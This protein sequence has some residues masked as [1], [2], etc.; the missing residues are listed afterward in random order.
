MSVSKYGAEAA[1]CWDLE[2]SSS[3]VQIIPHPLTQVSLGI[4]CLLKFAFF[5]AM[6]NAVF[7]QS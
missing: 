4:N 1:A 7:I 6:K 3:V 2:S 5:I